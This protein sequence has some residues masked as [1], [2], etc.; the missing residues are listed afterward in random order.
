[1][2]N[3]LFIGT[4][5]ASDTDQTDFDA[6]DLSVFPTGTAVTKDT[7]KIVSIVGDDGGDGA[8]QDNDAGNP[9]DSITYDLGSGSVTTVSD[10]TALVSVDL[11]L[12]DG[13]TVSLNAAFIQMANG[14]TFITDLSNAGNLDNLNIQN[15][16]ITGFPSG[17]NVLG[18]RIGQSV[19]GSNV[20]CF[21]KGTEILTESGY[22]K[23]EYLTKGMLIQTMD[24]GL[25]PVRWVSSK[26]TEEKEL[27]IRPSL[28][29]IRIKAGALGA[30][31]PSKDLL[32][33]R[34]HRIML[35]SKVVERIA[36]A[37]E[38][39]VP[40][41]KLLGIDGV[42]NS[43]EIAALEYFHICCDN[44]EII[45]ANGTPTESLFLGGEALKSL[46]EKARS[47]LSVIFPQLTKNRPVHVLARQLLVKQSR[48]DQL[49]RRH[50]KNNKHDFIVKLPNVTGEHSTCT[51]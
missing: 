18:W 45:L 38:V 34:Q 19:D 35:R 49:V 30:S 4:Y 22:V 31:T 8:Y 11:L 7:L 10:M 23:V 41:H 51:I 32:V 3:L 25:Q 24:N 1:M 17:T 44:H 15:V 16:T 12:G 37:S 2:E 9:G 26:K 42:K 27:V 46:T 50:K 39:L 43:D 20:V 47:E 29:P 21:C 28:K 36:D 6:E 13:T 33:S 5:A 14:D 48:V 40:A